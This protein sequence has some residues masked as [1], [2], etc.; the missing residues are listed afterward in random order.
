M[1][2]AQISLTISRHFSQSF[3]ASN[4]FQ[5]Y[6]P[7]PISS[8]SFCM[9]V[10]AGR[11]AFARLYVGVHR[12]TSLIS[13]SLL[14][15]QCPVCLVRL[16]WIV[17]MMGSRWPYSRCFVVCCRQDLLRHDSS[18]PGPVGW[19]CRIHQLHLC[20]GGRL[21]QKVSWI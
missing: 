3:I 1:P 16:T 2:L 12:S 9:Y 19:G 6:I 4:R 10:R 8:H 11:P 13:S 15:Q 21:L 20:K 18:S 7:Y 17:F 5:G 14:L